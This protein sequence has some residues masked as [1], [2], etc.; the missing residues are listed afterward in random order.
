MIIT[1]ADG[2]GPI[3]ESSRQGRR[4]FAQIVDTVFAGF[5]F[6]AVATRVWMRLN[7]PRRYNAAPSQELLVIRQTT[8]L[9]SAR[10]IS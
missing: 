7:V 10:A 9:V 3:D 1:R 6:W 2:A 5:D 8:R 4:T